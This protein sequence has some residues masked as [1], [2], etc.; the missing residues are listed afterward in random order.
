MKLIN[1]TDN[2]NNLSVKGK[3]GFLFRDTFFFGGLRAVRLLFPFITIPI[4]T[5]YFPV[6]EYGLYDSLMVISGFFSL[7]LVFG[8]DS[9]VAR[10]YYQVDDVESRKKVISEALLIQFVFITFFIPILLIFNKQFTIFYFHNT[11]FSKYV[12]IVIINSAFLLFINY[13][14]NILKWSFERKKYALLS[15]LNPLLLLVSLLIVIGFK[16]SIYNYL[17]INLLCSILVSLLGFSL[18]KKWFVLPKKLDYVKKLLVYGIPMGVIASTSALLPAI[19]RKMIIAFLDF[20]SLG[21]Y[22]LGYKVAGLILVI[23]GVFQ[24]AWGPFSLSIHKEKDAEK[25]YNIVVKAYLILFLFFIFILL[26]FAPFIIVNLSN[27]GYLSS[28]PLILP[29]TFALLLNGLSG[30]TGVGIGLSLKSYLNIIPFVFSVL[31]LVV[32]LNFLIPLYGIQGVAYSLLITNF[33]RMLIVSFISNKVY[34]PIQ[35]KYVNLI[36]IQ[37]LFLVIYFFVFHIKINV[38][39]SIVLFILSFV[40]LIFFFLDK[41]DRNYLLNL[42]LKKN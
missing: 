33:F 29:L 32:L 18:C 22:G 40:V 30:I 41:Q 21:I 34:R 23:D 1:N 35:I 2:P 37:L 9:S 25:V 31:V 36:L 15:I 14:I 6:E 39:Y 8:Q 20:Q 28:L 24:M 42:F 5:G 13:T 27:K 10:W 3:L 11:D 19:D 16:L 12:V 4:L 7:F 38:L 26:L 17:M